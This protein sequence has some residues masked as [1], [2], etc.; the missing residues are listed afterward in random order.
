VALTLLVLLDAL[1]FRN[2]LSGGLPSGVDSPFMYGLLPYFAAHGLHTFS[3]WLPE[4]FGQVQQFSLYW[5][6]AAVQGVVPSATVVY[7][8]ALF[9]AVLLVSVGMYCLAF[10]LTRSAIAAAMGAAIYTC[11]PFLVAQILAGHL[12]IV[13]TYGV[14]PIALWTA[15]VAL[16]TGRASAMIGL[17]LSAAVLFLLTTGQ[18]AYWALPLLI[19]GVSELVTPGGAVSRRRMALRAMLV[20]AV[21]LATFLAASAV[22]LVPTAAGESASYA[23]GSQHYVI[24][25]LS[26][27]AKYSL[28]FRDNAL[29]IPRELYLDPSLSITAA[30]FSSWPF[31]LA[32]LLLLALA[33]VCLRKR[34]P[35]RHVGI[36]LAAPMLLAWLLASGPHGPLPSLYRIYYNHVPYATF[37]RVP[38]RWLMVSG[39]CL[40]LMIAL[41]IAGLPSHAAKRRRFYPSNR[42]AIRT[43]GALVLFMSTFGVLHGLPSWSPPSAEGAAYAPLRQDRSDWRILTTP[44]YQSWMNALRGSDLTLQAD[45][46]TVST[47][48]HGRSVVGRGGWDPRAARFALYL[49]EVVEQGA[50]RDV[51]KLLGAAGVKYIALYPQRPLEVNAGQNTFFK[52][53]HFLRHVSD[54]GGVNIYRNTSALP[55]AYVT[56]ESCVI[57]GGLHVLGDLA[58][59]PWFSFRQVGLE[60]A[61][62]LAAVSGRA[63][64]LG[65]LRHSRCL[66]IAP[67]GANA[68]RVLLNAVSVADL[69]D[70]APAA[71]V[72]ADTSPSLDIG[73]EPT[74]PVYVPTGRSLAVQLRLAHEGSYRILIA[75]LHSPAQKKIA[76]EV[77]GHPAGSIGLG[78]IVGSGF[79]WSASQAEQLARGRQVVRLRV[80]APSGTLPAELTK[81]AIVPA[82]A[83]LASLSKDHLHLVHEAGGVGPLDFTAQQLSARQL[84]VKWNGAAPKRYVRVLR[85][86]K[87]GV[88]IVVRHAGR[89]YF[90]VARGYLSRAV[91]PNNLLAL[92]FRGAGSGRRIH[93]NFAY[94]LTSAPVAG[95]SF[96]DSTRKPRILAFSPLQPGFARAVPD[97]TAARVVMLATDSKKVLK[98]PLIVRGLYQLRR[99]SVRPAFTNVGRLASTSRSKL[100]NALARPSE[101]ISTEANLKRRLPRGL[102]VFTQSYNRGW[103]LTPNAGAAHTAVLGFANGYRIERPSQA[104]ALAFG[105]AVYGRIGTYLSIAAWIAGIVLIVRLVRGERRR[106]GPAHQNV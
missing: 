64:L 21:A 92:R 55:Q 20:G 5:L 14:G 12:D 102:L 17:G 59:Q 6:L 52:T 79:E 37:L 90:T 24:Q 34:S 38:N 94:S 85:R 31:R 36:I 57:A 9:S 40:A 83:G 99:P 78:S 1:M 33:L 43:A 103:A 7:D 67:G 15:W 8:A 74:P 32:A 72:G 39:A 22:Q 91:N 45:A 4:P 25:G 82:D 100:Q 18:G 41:T 49:E 65:E 98:R 71:W 101:M 16:R 62:Q 48:W 86:G 96:I 19:V 54:R 97:W 61:D 42:T 76:V 28:P 73:A 2:V 89:R 11:S 3:V 29:G 26:I 13:V 51:T 53:Q 87:S 30:S 88:A 104:R 27:H 105:P 77:N 10:W 23:S 58:E 50:N 56:K 95:F 69:A 93:L 70:S 47:W 106:D 60:F 35:F 46:G 75:G 66:I 81:I 63:G 44:Y 84:R 80:I 68:L